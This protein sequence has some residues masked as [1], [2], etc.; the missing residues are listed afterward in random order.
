MTL[1]PSPLMEPLT[2]LLGVPKPTPKPAA[3]RT[4]ESALELAQ[5]VR[6]AE[7]LSAV[8]AKRLGTLSTWPRFEG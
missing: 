4:R 1:Q 3:Q 2:T 7:Q 5:P 8:R 6:L